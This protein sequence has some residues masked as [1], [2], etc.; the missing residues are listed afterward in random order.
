[1]VTMEAAVYAFFGCAAGCAL[2]VPVHAF[3]Y[4]HLV[5]AQWGTPWALPLGPLGLIAAFVTFSALL[6]VRGP[7]RRIRGLTV[8]ETLGAE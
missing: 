3:L 2:G 4:R 5:T 1:M 8:V 7:A 6:A